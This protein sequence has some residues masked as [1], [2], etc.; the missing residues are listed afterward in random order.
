[1]C[2]VEVKLNI[3][4][5]GRRRQGRASKLSISRF[6]EAAYFTQTF[7]S[8]GATREARASTLYEIIAQVLACTLVIAQS[9][10][11]SLP[12]TRTAIPASTALE[13]RILVIAPLTEVEKESKK[14]WRT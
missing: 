2:C 11:C 5:F 10:Q 9:S 1:M 6:L 13:S 3:E 12:A 7:K 14:R 4:D 8:H